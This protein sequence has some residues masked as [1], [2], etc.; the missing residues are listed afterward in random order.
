M[1]GQGGEVLMYLATVADYLFALLV[2]QKTE[3][4][5]RFS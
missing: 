1:R 2:G 5:Q 3:R 4:D